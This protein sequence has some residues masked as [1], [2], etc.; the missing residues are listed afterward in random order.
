MNA[1]HIECKFAPM[2]ARFKVN[3]LS[4]HSNTEDHAVD[5]QQDRQGDFLRTAHPSAFSQLVTG[6]CARGRIRH[7]DHATITLPE[8]HRVVLNTETETVRNV[9]F[10]D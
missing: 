1:K 8:W 6:Q 2:G 7:P 4:M 10:L 9:A 5:I 3:V